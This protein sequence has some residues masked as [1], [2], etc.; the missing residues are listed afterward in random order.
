MMRKASLASGIALSV[1]CQR[2]SGMMHHNDYNAVIDKEGDLVAEDA[3]GR[4]SSF[5]DQSPGEPKA[6]AGAPVPEDWRSQRGPEVMQLPPIP[7]AAA[8]VGEAVSGHG[9]GL[10]AAQLHYETR[11][12][13]IEALRLSVIHLF[14]SEFMMS[15]FLQMHTWAPD[16]S[17]V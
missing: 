17:G 7:K 2:V 14:H 6:G 10:P 16:V 4:P 13:N 12:K 9:H 8:R 15:S 11:L 3:T 1:G 5:V